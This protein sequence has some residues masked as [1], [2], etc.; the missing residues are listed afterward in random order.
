M[1]ER[2]D[3]E[4]R[5][6]AAVQER[7]VAAVRR[8]QRLRRLELRARSP[9]LK[10]QLRIAMR[11]CLEL[12]W[13]ELE[14]PLRAIAGK[15]RRSG[16]M[17]EIEGQPEVV[18]GEEGSRSVL[19]KHA[20]FYIVDQLH[21]VQLNPDGNPRSYLVTIAW[22]GLTGDE[23]S[24]YSSTLRRGASQYLIVPLPEHRDDTEEQ[25]RHEQL[26][27]D[28]DLEALLAERLDN[29][30][31]RRLIEAFWEHSLSELD[32]QILRDRWETSPPR[33]F[34]DIAARLGEGWS[35]AAVRQRHQRAIVRTR[36]HL[37]ERGW[38]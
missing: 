22:R 38:L 24:I 34:A 3:D 13:A 25:G 28:E 36:E 10:A 17:Q 2:S 9:R 7:I 16:L 1:A 35:E 32:R 23:R 12:L 4:E 8:Y 14:Q 26:A 30:S 6:Q 11:H 18:R 37:R 29:A 19:A 31:C 5:S 20:F 15:W 33:S 21:T 27:S